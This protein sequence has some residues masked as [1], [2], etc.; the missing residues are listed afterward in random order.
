MALLLALAPVAPATASGP[1]D[2]A[3]G[4]DGD[5]GGGISVYSDTTSQ[6][7]ADAGRATA[8]VPVVDDPD[9][10]PGG[11]WGFLGNLVAM[12]GAMTVL[13]MALLLVVA[14]LPVILLAFIAWRLARR[15]ADRERAFLEAMRGEG[16]VPG[17]ALPQ[18]LQ[19]GELLWRK[20]IRNASIGFGLAAFS[21][22]VGW[23][24][25]AGLGFVIAIYGVGQAVMARTSARGGN[26][27]RGL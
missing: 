27:G 6:V 10:F 13:V 11:P 9:V 19:P 12:G 25:I 1:R 7:A 22:C 14:L 4:W 21:L 17:E 24:F 5:D 3:A 18:I 16:R 15:G 2:G 8:V 20:G 26:G 23:K